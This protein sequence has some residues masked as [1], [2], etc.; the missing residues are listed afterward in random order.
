MAV[1]EEHIRHRIIKILARESPA[2]AIR[3]I[4]GYLEQYYSS[5]WIRHLLG[6]L[7]YSTGDKIN[8]GRYWFLTEIKSSREN[9]CV[10]EYVKSKGMTKMAIARQQISHQC[11]SPKNLS[12]SARIRIRELLEEIIAEQGTLPKFATNWYGHVKSE[13]NATGDK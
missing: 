12:G 1:P 6:L 11:R 5:E 13:M 2:E 9:A 7:Y 10:E 3:R 8:A 4:Q